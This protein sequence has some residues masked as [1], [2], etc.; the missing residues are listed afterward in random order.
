MTVTIYTRPNCNTCDVIKAYLTKRGIHFT[1]APLTDEVL[2]EYA[3]H[4]FLSAPIVVHNGRPF[5]GWNSAR[6]AEIVRDHG[7]RA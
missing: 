3:D 5:A 4:G 6:M 7:E 1:T 2:A